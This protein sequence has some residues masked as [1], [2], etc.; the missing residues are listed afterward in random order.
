MESLMPCTLVRN[1]MHAYSY[2]S[3]TTATS[4]SSSSSSV[5]S[6]SSKLVVGGRSTWQGH[7]R[8]CKWRRRNGKKMKV[9]VGMKAMEMEV[10]SLA[11][12]VSASC[13][14]GSRGNRGSLSS[15]CELSSESAELVSSFG[16]LL[17]SAGILTAALIWLQN[18]IEEIAEQ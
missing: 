2:P 10:V 11:R 16:G 3:S 9:F 4:S 7:S 5:A 6:A 13:A 8:V 15:V 17:V 18:T 12:T 1:S 14:V